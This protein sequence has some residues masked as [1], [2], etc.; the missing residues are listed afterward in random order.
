M[1][2]KGL[3]GCEL[4]IAK[5]R[6]TGV[7]VLPW[8]P[9]QALRVRLFVGTSFR[10]VDVRKLKIVTSLVSLIDRS[11]EFTLITDSAHPGPRPAQLCVSYVVY[12]PVDPLSKS[13]K[14]QEYNYHEG[15]AENHLARCSPLRLGGWVV[16]PLG[17]S[18][19]RCGVVTDKTL[20]GSDLSLSVRDRADG[21]DRLTVYLP[22]TSIYRCGIVI[23]KTGSGSDFSPSV[24]N[25]ADD[26]DQLT[27]CSRECCLALW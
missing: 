11:C 13:R 19:Y 5:F 1:N 4:L 27:V 20:S 21:H 12:R 16:H 10:N 7:L 2:S 9:R 26:H 24:R 6:P 15:G 17:T 3:A 23:D 8:R 18:I 22:G 25:R 14:K